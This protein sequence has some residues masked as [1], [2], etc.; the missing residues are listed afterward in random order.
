MSIKYKDFYMKKIIILFLVFSFYGF[1]QKQYNFDHYAIYIG[2]NEINNCGY[3][4]LTFGNSKDHGYILEFGI[5]CKDE[6]TSIYLRLENLNKFIIFYNDPFPFK[7]FNP[8]IHLKSPYSRDL[9]RI[10]KNYETTFDKQE[11]NNLLETTTTFSIYKNSK[12]KKINY[13]IEVISFVSDKVLNQKFFFAHGSRFIKCNKINFSPNA[14]KSYKMIKDDKV[15]E[16]LELVELDKTTFS[17]NY[18]E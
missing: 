12:K 4:L 6:V 1:S 17:I 3:K 5:N 7:D 9:Y 18:K 8:E 2:R 10:I 16:S 14:I 13:K 11:I 15:L